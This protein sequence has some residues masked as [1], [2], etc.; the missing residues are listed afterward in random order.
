[1]DKAGKDRLFLSLQL[2]RIATGPPH[3]GQYFRKNNKFD[4]QST[5][6]PDSQKKKKVIILSK[7]LNISSIFTFRFLEKFHLI[8]ECLRL[9]MYQSNLNSSHVY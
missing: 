4:Y 7:N 3:Y 5:D 2:Y 1:M 9:Y 6:I 8:V